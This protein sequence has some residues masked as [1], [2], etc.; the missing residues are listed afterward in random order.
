V[1]SELFGHEK[2]AFTGAV[3]KEMGRFEIADNSTIF[4]DEIGELPPE[5][6]VKLLRVL[7]EGQFERLG[8]SRTITVDVRVM[9]ATNQNLDEAVRKGRFREDLYYR[10]NVFPITIPPLRERRE[11]IPLLVRTFVKEFSERMRKPIE[12]IPRKSMEAIQGYAWPG[13]VRE[14]RNVIERAMILSHGPTL[15]VD[16]PQKTDTA[17][18]RTQTLQEIERGHMLG[19][20]EQTG[21]RIRGE[22]GAAEILGLKPTTLEARMRKL[23]IQRTSW[24]A[25]Q[26]VPGG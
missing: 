6:Q 9:A 25:S 13:N 19:V 8:S 10:F 26:P 21:W 1:E 15:Q 17:V 18:Y 5:L 24:R 14:L 2:G 22:G 16:M 20:L 3:S 12:R 7:Q 23:G 11:D 4:L